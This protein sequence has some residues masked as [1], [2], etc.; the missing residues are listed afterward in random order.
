MF[1]DGISMLYFR[2]LRQREDKSCV[3]L[4]LRADTVSSLNTSPMCDHVRREYAILR[5]P[6]YASIHLD[7]A[8]AVILRTRF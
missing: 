4:D 7:K 2:F 5:E 1:V 3:C 6:E 8:C